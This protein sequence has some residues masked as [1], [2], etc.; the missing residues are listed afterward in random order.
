MKARV[1][2]QFDLARTARHPQ[3]VQGR[4]QV[5][6]AVGGDRL[7]FFPDQD[8]PRHLQWTCQVELREARLEQQA[9]GG[10]VAFH[11]VAGSLALAVSVRGLKPARDFAYLGGSSRI[12]C[13]K[14]PMPWGMTF[15][16]RGPIRPPLCTCKGG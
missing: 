2:R 13:K 3:H 1:C 11:G 14:S 10:V 15:H 7:Q 6:A 8:A 16:L 9:D 5:Q 4:L 12:S